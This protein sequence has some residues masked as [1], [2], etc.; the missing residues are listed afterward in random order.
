MLT[1]ALDLISPC[2]SLTKVIGLSFLDESTIVANNIYFKPEN[3]NDVIIM[4]NMI[5]KYGHGYIFTKMT[6]E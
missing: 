4:F 1:Y 5:L 2:E 6:G 3:I